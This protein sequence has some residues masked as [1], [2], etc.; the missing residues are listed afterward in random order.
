MQ[1]RPEP[2]YYK[3]SFHD[4]HSRLAQTCFDSADQSRKW[5]PKH[6]K[7]ARLRTCAPSGR[8]LVGAAV[9]LPLGLMTQ[10]VQLEDGPELEPET[11]GW[12]SGVSPRGI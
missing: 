2:K 7:V 6:E 5:A 12:T 11:A 3:K 4:T 1:Q 8:N 9:N 10:D